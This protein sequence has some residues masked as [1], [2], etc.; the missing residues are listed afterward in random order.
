MSLTSYRA[1]PP[2]DPLRA[3]IWRPRRGA[4]VLSLKA[5]GSGGQRSAVRRLA[6]RVDVGRGAG[7]WVAAPA[8]GVGTW[9]IRV[10]LAG[11]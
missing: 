1:A 10:G 7:L 5:L 11:R 3:G 8:A 9:N 2:R 4:Q 6:R